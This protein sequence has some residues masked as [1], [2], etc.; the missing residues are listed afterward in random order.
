MYL[1]FFMDYA[2]GYMESHGITVY[3]SHRLQRF[4]SIK[5]L[6][7]IRTYGTSPMTCHEDDIDFLQSLSTLD[8]QIH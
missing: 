3:L 1:F 2:I 4:H 7:E 6:I 8:S 5:R